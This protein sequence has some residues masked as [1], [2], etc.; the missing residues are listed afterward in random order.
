MNLTLDLA[1]DSPSFPAGQQWKFPWQH[2]EGQCGGVKCLCEK[3]RGFHS[4]SCSVMNLQ[5][6]CP[7]GFPAPH[8][9]SGGLLR[10]QN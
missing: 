10:S 8:M 2:K 1:A 6:F 9:D 3:S 5:S 7:D 4:M